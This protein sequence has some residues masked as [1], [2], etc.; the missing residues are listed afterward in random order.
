M[1]KQSKSTGKGK[2]PADAGSAPEWKLVTAAGETA[3]AGVKKQPAGETA[4]KAASAAARHGRG[5]GPKSTEAALA[6][7]G[8][9]VPA[10]GFG[11]FHAL[12]FWGLMMLLFL[13]P[14]FRGLFFAPDQEVAL[15]AAGL[16]FLGAG[17]WRWSLQQ[18]HRF[19]SSPLDWAVLALPAVYLA[20]A[21][22]AANYG[23]AVDGVVKTALY[24]LVF[25]LVSRLALNE[26]HA[27]TLMRVVWAAA[28]GV[29]LAGLATAT[30]FIEIKDGFL[31]GR[32]Y[33]TFQYPNALASFLAAAIFF[34]VC[35][36]LRSFPDG[37][38]GVES[39]APAGGT[40]A[41]GAAGPR[42]KKG[43]ENLL[44][45][46]LNN[47]LMYRYL[48]S[49]GNYL[50]FSVLA[51]SKS[52]GGL[53]VF[54]LAFAL[55]LI[56]LPRGRRVPAFLQL[57]L[58]AVP[59]VLAIRQFLAEVAANRPDP[60]WLWIFAGLAVVLAG[61]ALFDLA[62][63]RGLLPWI[64]AH[65]KVIL[66]VLLL[67]LV[68]GGIGL[69]LYVNSHA[70][71]VKALGEEIRLRNAT[72]R[73]Y[74]YRDA[75]KMFGERPLLGWG[76]GG[77]QEAYRSYQSY[78]YN[79]N[80]VHGYYLQVLVETGVVG[81]LAVAAIWAF[82]LYGAHRL[83]HGAKQQPAR[84]TLVWTAAVAAV[85][86]GLHAAIDFD[87]SLS[88]L[89]LVLLSMF[90]L[91]RGLE[92]SAAG[93]VR[94]SGK[95][96]RRKSYEAPKYGVMASCLAGALAIMI[97]AGVLAA[98]NNYYK[99]AGSFLNGGN[100][101]QAEQLLQKAIAYNPANAD[102]HRTLAG[103]YQ[104]SGKLDQAMA[105]AR[106]AS[107]LSKYSPAP[108]A[109]MANIALNQNQAPEA[110]D[111]AERALAL[112]PFQ[113]Q[114]YEYLARINFTAGFSAM[115]GG[116][117]ETAKQ[118]LTKTT[119]IPAR[120]DAQMATLGETE[121]KLWNVAPLMTATPAVR[122]AV[123]ESQYLLGRWPEAEANLQGAMQDEKSKGEALVWLAALRDKQGRA[124]EAQELLA[125][126][127]KLAP[128]LA[129]GYEGLRGLEVF[130]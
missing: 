63:R 15:A 94:Q 109:A 86:I 105:E 18:Q 50:I 16:I 71:A 99:Q 127:Q 23:L 68:A 85:S 111:Y 47:D 126:A 5:S 54:T 96:G 77:W 62:A 124:G 67:L 93:A 117:R 92:I 122:L 1:S 83:Y 30:G 102:F 120:I 7:P 38:T 125:Q 41:A 121:K 113:S 29:A 24:F 76:G 73:G 80:E 98:S 36:W 104:Q 64:A 53:L 58:A 114:W 74:F 11:S 82:F 9:T 44:P 57:T 10:A 70:E 48:G 59:A 28:A 100:I 97:F 56:G 101:R 84:Q 49:A 79:S 89:T 22:Q 39:A 27:A 42:R 69:S 118:Y 40:A 123:G 75:L 19:L 88:A 26:I 106:A 52:Q 90:G 81:L 116:D 119:E 17:F 112:A 87:L 103:L 95:A 55:F 31:N 60:A 115:N 61:Q 51:G 32:I 20:S 33:S 65:K 35:L 110:V 8:Q 37:W 12:I 66:A 107:G 43:E 72:E 6:A 45:D 128:E 130:E 13:A 4:R 3:A 2:K 108:L 21:F 46:W 129:K 25:W 34:G 14:Y 91:V 78:L